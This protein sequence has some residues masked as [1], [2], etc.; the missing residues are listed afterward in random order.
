MLM[1]CVQC[2][3]SWRQFFGAPP[4]PILSQGARWGGFWIDSSSSPHSCGIGHG[5]VLSGHGTGWIFCPP[6]DPD[7]LSRAASA[8]WNRG[9]R[10]SG[11]VP[12]R[13]SRCSWGRFRGWTPARGAS[14]AG[15]RGRGGA[16]ESPPSGSLFSRETF[17]SHPPALCKAPTPGIRCSRNPGCGPLGRSPWPHDFR[18]GGPFGDRSP[19]YSFLLVKRPG[20]QGWPA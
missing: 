18:W 7:R 1:G 20:D 12:R 8:F 16:W 2:Q 11:F 5:Q 13:R 19:G 6:P 3:G 15:L 17:F 10:H 9:L 14:G 4:P